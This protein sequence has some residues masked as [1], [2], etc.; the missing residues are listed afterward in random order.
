M[1]SNS[2]AVLSNILPG[3]LSECAWTIPEDLPEGDWVRHGAFLGTLD[4][5]VSWWLGDWWAHGEHKYG[6]RKALVE[7]DDWPGPEYRTCH[8]AGG[9]CRAF[10]SD[11]RRSLLTFTHH[12]EVASL[13][14]RKPDKAEELLKWCEE[15]IKETGRPRSVRELREY[16]NRIESPGAQPSDG[17]CTEEDLSILCASGKRFGCIYADPPWL[18]DNQGTRA[19]TKNHYSGMTVEE[20]TAL[21]IGE[22]A[23]PDSH[24]HLWITNGFLFDAPKIF[25][26]WGFEFRSSFIWVKPQ[27]GIGNYWRNAHEILLTAIRGKAKRFNDKSLKSWLECK[28]GEH[29]AKPEQVRGFVQRASPGPYLELFGR[30]K[31]KGW[32]VW[33]N[34]IEKN[35]FHGDPVIVPFIP[36]ETVITRSFD[37]AF[38]KEATV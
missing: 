35:L 16:S 15:T 34:Q 2:L 7:H 28:R 9:V 8:N 21:P 29:S 33:G 23:A 14:A 27:I 37:E 18:Y 26:A 5:S 32:T 11:R 10:T 25:A 22:L 24:L 12:A 17:T 13:A 19:A 20:I 6:D 36:T 3:V 38:G 1:S 4:R 30:S 31:V